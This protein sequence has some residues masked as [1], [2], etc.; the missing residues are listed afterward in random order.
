MSPPKLSNLS[1]E[2]IYPRRLAPF[3]VREE[4]IFVLGMKERS[5]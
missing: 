3:I 2:M 1:I 4:A 5:C